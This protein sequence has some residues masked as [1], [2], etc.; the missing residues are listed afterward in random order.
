[1]KRVAKP[2]TERPVTFYLLIFRAKARLSALP[3]EA[4]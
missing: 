3:R 2:K 4:M 1:M